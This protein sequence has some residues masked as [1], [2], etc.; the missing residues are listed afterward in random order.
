VT[1]EIAQLIDDGRISWAGR[2]FD[3]VDLSGVSLVVVA[4][5]TKRCR[6]GLATRPRRAACRCTRSTGPAAVELHRCR[7]SSTAARITIAI[8]TGGVARRWPQAARRDRARAARRDRQAGALRR[9]LPRPGAPHLLSRARGA[10]LDRVFDGRVGE[11]ALAGDEI[12]ARRELI[13]LLYSRAATAPRARAMVH[14]VGAGPA[15]PTLLT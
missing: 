6:R 5:A 14:L 8:S 3:E 9:D 10:V 1:G 4:T 7:R 2:T 13:R 11:L 12:A 15:I